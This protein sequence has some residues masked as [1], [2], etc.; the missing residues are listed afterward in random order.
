MHIVSN[1]ALISINETLFIQLISFLI[2][3]FLINRIMFRPLQNVMG[4]REEHLQDITTNIE[5]SEIQ[6]TEMNE[7]VRAQELAAIQEANQ[8]K[9]VLESDGATQANKILEE[10]RKE[11]QTI[12]HESQQYIDG[13]ISKAREDIKKE[14]EKLA[15]IIMERVLDRRLA[16]D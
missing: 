2:F 14:S 4:E 11:I 12:K 1:I 7:Q 9:K 3:L 10:S 8:Q 16:T 15:V 13:Q 5:K 6:L